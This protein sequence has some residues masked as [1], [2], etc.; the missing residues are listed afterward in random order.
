MYVLFKFF[1]DGCKIPAVLSTLL[2]FSMKL[3]HPALSTTHFEDK[4]KKKD[5]R[6]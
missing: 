3:L 4:M 2:D 1:L 5:K 6:D